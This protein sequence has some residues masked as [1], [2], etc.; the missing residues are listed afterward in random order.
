MKKK[1]VLIIITLLIVMVYYFP[2]NIKAQQDTTYASASIIENT[3]TKNGLP[4]TTTSDFHFKKGTDEYKGLKAL[5]SKISY[6]HCFKTL[7]SEYV[8][9]NNSKRISLFINDQFVTIL[10]NDI[11]IGD[12]VYCL[13]YLGTSSLHQDIL[14]LL[15]ES[16]D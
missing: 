2:M 5:T 7:Q 4:K 16:S 1:Y 8:I 14:T 9:K 12:N 3:T 10:N 13:N 15:E 6:H 11:M